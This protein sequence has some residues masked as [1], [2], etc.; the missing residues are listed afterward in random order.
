MDLKI[1]KSKSLD[2]L[3][4]LLRKLKPLIEDKELGQELDDTLDKLDDSFLLRMLLEQISEKYKLTENHL[5]EKNYLKNGHA[6]HGDWFER[7]SAGKPSKTIV[8]HIGKDTYGYFHPFE[9][10][11]ITIREAARIQSFPDWFKF[12]AEETGVV[13]TYTSIGNAVA[14]L[15]AN[16]FAKIL[17][18]FEETHGLFKSD[19][20]KQPILRRRAEQF[21]LNV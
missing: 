16:H 17:I 8:A 13:D 2:E 19:E 11:A 3:V 15:M 21:A 14:P 18:E 7:L 4:L 12:G 10:R 5:L 1:H 6:H 9:N 20:L